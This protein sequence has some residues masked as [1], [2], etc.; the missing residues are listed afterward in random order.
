MAGTS[1][2][3]I[4]WR[5]FV[6]HANAKEIRGVNG[7]TITASTETEDKTNNGET[8]VARKNAGATE[9]SL[10]AILNA[11]LGIDVKAEAVK[12]LEAAQSSQT[13]YFYAGNE[14]LVPY[15]F[16]LIKANTKN[17]QLSPNGTWIHAEI[18]MTMKQCTKYD[19][20]TNSASSSNN[21]NNNKK[22]TLTDEAKTKIK[23]S[24]QEKITNVAE[25]AKNVVTKLGDAL[26]TAVQATSAA[27]QQSQQAYSNLTTKKTTTTTPKVTL[28]PVKI[29]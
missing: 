7:I 10:T 4:R 26:K 18:E 28:V 5:D 16:M 27:K 14:K 22:I 19:G 11:Y 20:T 9:I 25:A 1:I 24:M 15:Q 23:D 13:G 3:L 6:F 8:Y 2:D 12:M 17:V 21:N 29:K